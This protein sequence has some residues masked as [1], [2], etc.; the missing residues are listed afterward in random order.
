M[1]QLFG[2]A[3]KEKSQKVKSEPEEVPGVEETDTL[4]KSWAE[5]G[6]CG[7]LS[8]RTEEVTRRSRWPVQSNGGHRKSWKQRPREGFGFGRR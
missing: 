6:M 8:I 4:S 1:A 7:I 2:E 3:W 5:F